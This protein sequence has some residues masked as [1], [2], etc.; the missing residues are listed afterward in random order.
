MALLEITK[1]RE[2][3]DTELIDALKQAKQDLWTARFSLSTRQLNDTSTIPQTRRAIAR[4]MTVQRERGSGY[5]PKIE[6]APAPA[7]KAG[8][9]KAG[10]AKATR[11]AKP[12][13]AA[14]ATKPKATRTTKAT[15][16]TA[17]AAK[18]SA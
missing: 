18:Q 9:A 15:K 16:T 14:K 4:I 10:A 1:I 7:K 11:A 17:A 13:K 6:A 2:M 5:V 12:A 3:S 8:A